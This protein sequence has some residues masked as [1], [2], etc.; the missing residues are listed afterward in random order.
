MKVVDRSTGMV[1][2]ENYVKK[3]EKVKAKLEKGLV[4]NKSDFIEAGITKASVGDAL[5]K[6]KNGL[7]L[8]VLSIRRGNALIGWVLADEIL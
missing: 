7:G 3:L 4:V 2:T 8:D 6:L 5:L 1:V